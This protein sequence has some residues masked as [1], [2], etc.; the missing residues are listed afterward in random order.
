MQG[1]T[2]AVVEI[3]ID[4]AGIDE[5]LKAV[6]EAQKEFYDRVNSLRDAITDGFAIRLTSGSKIRQIRTAEDLMQTM[7]GL[8]HWKGAPSKEEILAFVDELLKR[9]RVGYS[10]K[11]NYTHCKGLC[12]LPK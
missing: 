9:A 2:K 5:K 1:K 7:T 12:Q 11:W 6:I 4:D 3:V 8:G 10:G